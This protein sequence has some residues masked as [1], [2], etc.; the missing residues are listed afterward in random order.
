MFVFPCS[1]AGILSMYCRS[2]HRSCTPQAVRFVCLVFSLTTGLTSLLA[3]ILLDELEKAHK[4]W[5]NRE[6]FSSAGLTTL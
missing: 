1:F 3:V 5:L 4:V 2:A 6:R